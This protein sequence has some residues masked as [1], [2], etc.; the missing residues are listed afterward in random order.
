MAPKRTKSQKASAPK[1][2]RKS[3]SLDDKLEII[4]RYER[5]QSTAEI[6]HALNIPESTL[7]TIR[8][9]KERI[10]ASVQLGGSSGFWGSQENDV[11]SKFSPE[12]DQRD[13]KGLD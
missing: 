9:G 5:G 10:K 7:R 12:E 4:R 13:A 6:K 2:A 1:R 3:L 11:R 8:D